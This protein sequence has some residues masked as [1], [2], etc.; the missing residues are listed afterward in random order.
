MLTPIKVRNFDNYSYVLN[1]VNL[2][3]F[4]QYQN[5]LLHAFCV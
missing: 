1:M 4:M 2:G 5:L 3:C